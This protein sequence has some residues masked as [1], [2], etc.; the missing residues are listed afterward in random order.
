MRMELL[1]VGQLNKKSNMTYK[2]KS[3]TIGKKGTIQYGKIT[4]NVEVKDY[5]FT[6]GHDRWLVSPISGKGE[7][8]VEDVTF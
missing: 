4:I 2:E 3:E 8:W 5:K 1:S 6:Y 7:M